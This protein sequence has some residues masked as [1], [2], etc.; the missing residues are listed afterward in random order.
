MKQKKGFTLIEL[1]G[2]IVILGII[3]LIAT[4]PV[5]NQIKKA[6]GKLKTSSLTYIYSAGESY[7][8]E[9]EESYP[10]VSGS[11]FCISIQQLSD[12]GNLKDSFIKQE[13]ID[14]D[15][16][17]KFTVDANLKLTHEMQLETSTSCKSSNA[18]M[19]AK[20]YIVET[21]MPQYRSRT[22]TETSVPVHYTYQGNDPHNYMEFKVGSVTEL[23]RIVG[24]DATGIKIT[25]AT[26]EVK[27]PYDSSNA[28]PTASNSYCNNPSKGCNAF[29]KNDKT[30]KNDSEIYTYLNTTYYRGITDNLMKTSLINMA[31]Y[32]IGK[33]DSSTMKTVDQINEAIKQ[34]NTSV[35]VGLLTVYDYI[36]ATTEEACKNNVFH[37]TACGTN[38]YLKSTNQDYWLINTNSKNSN[39]VF[40]VLQDGQIKEKVASD[41]NTYYRPV[42]YLKDSISLIGSGTKA[43]P[44]KIK[45]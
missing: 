24:F 44:F 10:K 9:N 31:N 36:S 13:G 8:K 38:N 20:A 22:K 17:L 18:P 12:N 23:W 43:S 26:F 15:A 7:I 2:T 4:P 34:D 5:I 45:N 6:K 25:P 32:P 11:V 35:Q 16:V 39:D 1:L 33:L 37:N 41:T 14:Y 28:R 19:S 27:R 30:V 21:T 3:T 40:S 29:I 42:I